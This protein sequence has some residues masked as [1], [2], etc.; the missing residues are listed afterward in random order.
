MKEPIQK[1]FRLGILQWMSYPRREPM[2][3]LKTILL[4]DFFTVVETEGFHDSEKNTAARALIEQSRVAVSVAAHPVLLGQKLNPNALDESQRLAAEKSLLVTVDDA[5]ALGSDAISFLAGPYDPQRQEEAFSQL[6]KT[7]RT[8]CQYAKDRGIHVELEV[9]DY[10]VDK[11]SLI[12]PAPYAARFADQ[13]RREYDNFGLL[14][15]L[16]H[17]P[18]T[19]ETSAFTIGTL[20]PYITHFHY[21]NA[22]L[23]PGCD[24]YGDKHPRF[25]Y[26]HSVNG[27]EELAEFLR[28]LKAEGFFCPE[29]PYI[30]SMEVAPRPQED[31]DLVVAG[32]KRALLQAWA[33]VD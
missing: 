7:T 22:V 5:V 33:M 27:V 8:V 31:E 13:I 18:I 29:A 1:Y 23:T 20:R 19:H 2:E 32:T 14:V 17:I 6:L 30:L 16:S 15:D 26:P 25:D 28:V 11:C 21:G 10:D 4:D 12:G 9:F 3:A 24:A